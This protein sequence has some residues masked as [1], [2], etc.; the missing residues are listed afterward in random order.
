MTSNCT[1]MVLCFAFSVAYLLGATVATVA[2]G[3]RETPK[4]EPANAAEAAAR[5]AQA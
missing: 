4:G 5:K 1:R 2:H 3:A